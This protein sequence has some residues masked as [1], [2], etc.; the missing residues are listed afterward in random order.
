VFD[1]HFIA[2]FITFAFYLFGLLFSDMVVLFS[3]DLK[4]G[5]FVQTPT[6]FI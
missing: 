1:V 5:L 6:A 4:L 3:F 2:N